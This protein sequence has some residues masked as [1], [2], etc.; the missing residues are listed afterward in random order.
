[1][2]LSSPFSL[3]TTEDTLL[4]DTILERGVN[5][6]LPPSFR[7][8]ISDPASLRFTETGARVSITPPSVHWVSDHSPSGIMGVGTN[9]DPLPNLY[10]LTP[11][12]ANEGGEC[13]GE[14]WEYRVCTF[15]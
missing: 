10:P 5:E 11:L 1:M 15:Q 14:S 2:V 8:I 4:R 9:R 3:L 6:P 7:D 13:G 12:M